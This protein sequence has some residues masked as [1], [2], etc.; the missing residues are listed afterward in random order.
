MWL[1]IDK[2]IHHDNVY[3]PVIRPRSHLTGCDPDSCDARVI[4]EDAQEGKA[5]ITWRSR[6]ETAEYQHAVAVEVLHPRAG[7]AR[8]RAPPARPDPIRFVNICENR[9]EATDRC[10]R[11]PIGAGY[12]EQ[13]FGEVAAYRGEQAQR[14]E[15]AEGG[16]V[17][18]VVEEPFKATLRPARW[19]EPE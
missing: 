5:R 12:E 14:T 10:W 11:S 18:W 3:F 13:S 9:A 15:G 7:P 8:V 4:K 6:D 1:A 2:V 16:T 17:G 19:G